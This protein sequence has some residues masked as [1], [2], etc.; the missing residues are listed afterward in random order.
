MAELEIQKA[1]LENQLLQSEIELNQAKAR[2][3]DAKKDQADLDF[4]EQETGTAHERDMQKQRAQS[5][6]NQNLQVT[7]ALTTPQKEGER[8]PDLAA[9]IGFNHISDKLNDDQ[10]SSTIQRDELV[11]QQPSANLRSPN[12]D[13]SRDPALNPAVRI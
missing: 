13:P 2:A 11:G 7:K 1:E 4:V 9:A 5:Q 3:E 10:P 6:G 8:K 12:F